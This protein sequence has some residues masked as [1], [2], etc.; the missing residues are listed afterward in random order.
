MNRIIIGKIKIELIEGKNPLISFECEDKEQL[1][2]V[3]HI[4]DREIQKAE[5]NGRLEIIN[6]MVSAITKF[7]S[8][9]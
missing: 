5:E 9:K 8:S 7:A 2:L 6:N 3:Y 1:N 4:Y